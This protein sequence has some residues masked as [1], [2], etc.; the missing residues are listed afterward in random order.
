MLLFFPD[1]MPHFVGDFLSE[2]MYDS[3]LATTHANGSNICCRFVDVTPSWQDK[4]EDGKSW[5]VSNK[6]QL[7]FLFR[8]NH[9]FQNINEALTIIEICKKYKRERRQFRSKVSISLYINK[10]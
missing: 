1:R 9:I 8:P 7:F 4:G 6:F 2:R 10:F 3:A 5:I